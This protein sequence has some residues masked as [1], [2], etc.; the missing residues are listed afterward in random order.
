MRVTKATLMPL[1]ADCA[2][3]VQLH[4]ERSRTDES[5]TGRVEHIATGKST[6]FH[7]LHELTEFLGARASGSKRGGGNP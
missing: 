6:F 2:Y 3:I 5:L 1:P 4:G 7:S